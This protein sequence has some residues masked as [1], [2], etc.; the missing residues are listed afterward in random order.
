MKRK[1]MYMRFAVQSKEDKKKMYVIETSMYSEIS[2]L[3]SKSYDDKAK[4]IFAHC[5]EK[6]PASQSRAIIG[7]PAIHN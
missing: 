2:S 7:P 5:F 6:S 1:Y 3:F 4:H